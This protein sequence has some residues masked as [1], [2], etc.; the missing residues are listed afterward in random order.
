MN[1]VQSL[2]Q[3]CA[4][5]PEGPAA[6]L[7]WRAAERMLEASICS[8]MTGWTSGACAKAMGMASGEESCA[9][10]CLAF[11]VSST[12]CELGSLLLVG[13]LTCRTP[14]LPFWDSSCKAAVVLPLNIKLEKVRSS[15]FIF[16]VEKQGFGRRACRALPSCIRLFMSPST[17]ESSLL[18][19]Q[20]V[21]ILGFELRAGFCRSSTD[22]TVTAF[23]ATDSRA[24]PSA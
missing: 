16:F 3:Q 19:K 5:R 8:K 7:V 14:P 4:S 11:S 15:L 12:V 6:P 22:I 9:G 13:S 1:E 21:R 20:A 17:Q 2:L 24:E 23:S 10:G 18:S